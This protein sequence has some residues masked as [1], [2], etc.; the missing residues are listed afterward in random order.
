MNHTAIETAAGQ[1]AKA[2]HSYRWLIGAGAREWAAAQKQS[3]HEEFR[4]LADALGYDVTRR[5]NDQG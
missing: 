2:A 4:R 1:I 5:E 3:I